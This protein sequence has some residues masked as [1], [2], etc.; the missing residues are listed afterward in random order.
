MRRRASSNANRNTGVK[1]RAA[2]RMDWPWLNSIFISAI[3]S[4]DIAAATSFF[5]MYVDLAARIP[6]L[7]RH[8]PQK[9]HDLFV[10]YQD[11]IIFGTDFQS[12]ENKMI[13]GSSG[14]EPPPTEADAI[15]FFLK[16][17]RWLET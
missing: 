12:L 8:D 14:N 4:G 6:E 13:L 16:E 3:F 1:P 2:T 15:V 17:Y 7:G 10:K 11:R 9:V 5:I